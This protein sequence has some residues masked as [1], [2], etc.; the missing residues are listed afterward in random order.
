[1]SSKQQTLDK[2]PLIVPVEGIVS[3]STIIKLPREGM[4]KPESKGGRGDLYV[5]FNIEFPSFISQEDKKILE[6][7][8]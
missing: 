2:K 4:P 1:L 7:I 6:E 8:L 3:P 5:K